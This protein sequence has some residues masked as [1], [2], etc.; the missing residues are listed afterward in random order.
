MFSPHLRNSQQSWKIKDYSATFHGKERIIPAIFLA[1]ERI[2]LAKFLNNV[3]LQKRPISDLA[4]ILM[5]ILSLSL[6]QSIFGLDDIFQ[7]LI[8][9]SWSAMLFI[10][11]FYRATFVTVTLPNS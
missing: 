11:A 3:L 6:N 10:L 5:L 8:W 7:I 1:K 9:S 2:I 4:Q